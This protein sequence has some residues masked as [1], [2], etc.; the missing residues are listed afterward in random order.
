MTTVR[1]AVVLMAGQGSRLRGTQKA[2]LKPFIPIL[3][4]PLISFT[5]DMLIGA[6]VYQVAGVHIWPLLRKT[7]VKPTAA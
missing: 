2:F 4:R 3:G 1:D 6:G 7:P 5:L